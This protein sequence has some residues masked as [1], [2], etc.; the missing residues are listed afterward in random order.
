M[1]AEHRGLSAREQK[2]LE[3]V[4]ETLVPSIPR[5]EDP[6]GFFAV[7]ARQADTLDR[8]ARLI[9]SVPSPADRKRLKVLLRMLDNPIVNLL[10]AGKFAAF[11]AL[12]VGDR[13][14]VLRGYSRS[15]IPLRRAGFQALKRLVHFAHYCWPV[16][17]RH[18][19]WEV[20]GY[21]TAA[22]TLPPPSIH[23]RSSRLIAIPS[24]TAT[25]WSRAP[26]PAA[27]W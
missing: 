15:R 2:V 8:A 9:E 5:S 18:P 19:A 6:G 16:G 13:E 1:A 7:G 10:F 25:S 14:A 26:E 27:A 11:T 23:C 4:C 12:P 3:A 21:P 22:R 20:N 24:S 17:R